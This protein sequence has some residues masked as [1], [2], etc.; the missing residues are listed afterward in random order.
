MKGH[1]ALVT[2]ASS[3][4]G[5]ATGLYFAA[6]GAKVAVVARRREKLDAL[7]AEIADGDGDALAIAADLTLAE[8]IERAVAATVDHFGR[9]DTLVNAAGII[10]MGD[11]ANTRLED[12]DTMMNINARSP[13]YMIQRALPHLIETKGSV[14]NVSSVTGLRSFPGVLAYCASKAAADQLTR[15]AALEV[16]DKGVRINAINPGVVETN[17][18]REAGMD[19]AAYAAFL[20]HSETTHPLGRVGQPEEVAALIHFLASD[21]AQW[22][23]GA[24]IPIDGGRALTCAR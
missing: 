19:A 2:G 6:K 16:A 9:L 12:W 10:G 8:D 5:W 13:F 7:V 21:E 18:H 4:I 3:G 15:C 24:T 11:V 14:V 22:I 23:T 1:V 17:L 20:K